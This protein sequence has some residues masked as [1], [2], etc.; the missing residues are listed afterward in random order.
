MSCQPDGVIFKYTTKAGRGEVEQPRLLSG[1][2]TEL[3]TQP[4]RTC[5]L[6]AVAQSEH[7]LQQAVRGQLYRLS[8]Q[9]QHR[10]QAPL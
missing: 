5:V 1:D 4:A 7:Q 3:L 2:S 10:L 9:A 6:Q 8:H